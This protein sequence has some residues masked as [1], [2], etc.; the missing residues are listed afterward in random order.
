MTATRATA[1][2]F[3]LTLL[4]P[5]AAAAFEVCDAAKDPSQFAPHDRWAVIA[6]QGQDGWVF[7][8]GELLVPG[9]LGSS[10]APLARLATALRAK[11]V[12]PYLVD[13]P[14]RLT[15]SESKL[16]RSRSEF[17]GYADG[18]M[19]ASYARK[20]KELRAAGWNVIDVVELGKS[21]GL[22]P[23]MFMDRDH[24]WSTAA[25]RV[26]A[27]ELARQLAALPTWA[28]VPKTA[29]ELKE[30]A[31]KYSGTYRF[32]VVDK[33]KIDL[34]ATESVAYKATSDEE[35][36][37]ESLLGDVAAPEVVLVGT[38]QS[39]RQDYDLVSGGPIFEDSF[40]ALLRYS[41]GADL[42]NLAVEGGGTYTSI[43]AWLT[44]REYQRGTPKVLIWEM[45][46]TDGFADPAALRRVVPAA[47]GWCP[48]PAASGKGQLGGDRPK[49]AVE[50]S[51]G[52]AGH[53]WYVGV[54]LTDTSLTDFDLTFVQGA[55]A[56]RVEVTRSKL[57]P[58]SGMFFV[59][60]SDAYDS[61]LDEVI[62]D[63]RGAGAGA[64]EVRV[65]KA[66]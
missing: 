35:V 15:L 4:L 19:A 53:D 34:P 42:L 33:C 38:S 39:R 60:L 1:L 13:V 47:W 36:S 54:K 65:C 17:S 24:H 18:S 56:E 16:D 37:A 43:E 52:A 10:T 55:R 12:A 20:V 8:K 23:D 32:I 9:D 45:N 48:S 58:N 51:V 7:A 6:E 28:S 11:G 25:E 31:V 14:G 5:G 64:W 41:L 59:E 2:L 49:V 44:S 46:D 3:A 50:R 40:A 61:P 29:F 62:V 26:V 27:E 30:R 66:G 21:S 57:L 63:T 22:G